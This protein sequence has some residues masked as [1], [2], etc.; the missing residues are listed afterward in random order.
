MMLH[1]QYMAFVLCSLQR[2]EQ[3]LWEGETTLLLPMRLYFLKQLQLTLSLAVLRQFL[4]YGFCLTNTFKCPGFM[5]SNRRTNLYVESGITWK[6]F[7]CFYSPFI[8]L[9]SFLWGSFSFQAVSSFC[10][11]ASA[12]WYENLKKQLH[13]PLLFQVSYLKWLYFV[14]LLVCVCICCPYPDREKRVK[15]C[16]D[17]Q[18]FL[19]L[20][21]K[22]MNFIIECVK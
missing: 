20:M 13:S 5:L 16:K 4:W 2:L 1:R 21:L 12:M 15:Y 7:Y 3:W 11:Y 10:V 19:E 9:V 22:K 18:W 6:D 17:I 8:G 14:H